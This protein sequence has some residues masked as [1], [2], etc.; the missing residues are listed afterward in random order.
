MEKWAIKRIG[1]KSLLVVTVI[2]LLAVPFHYWTVDK[3]GVLRNLYPATALLSSWTTSCSNAAPD[4]QFEMMNFG[5]WNLRAAASQ[6]AFIDRSGNL[7]HCESG[8]EGEITSSP[9]VTETSLFQYGS[10]TKPIT[11]ALIINLN[12]QDRLRFEQSVLEIFSGGI[13]NN[14]SNRFEVVTVGNLMRFTAGVSGEAFVDK[15]D[16]WCPYRMNEI[17]KQKPWVAKDKGHRYSNLSYCILGG[18]ASELTG[19]AYRPLVSET[20]DLESYGIKFVD[21]PSQKGWVSPDYRYHD[22]YRDDL[23]PS[24]DYTSISSTGGLGGSAEGYARLIRRLLDLSFSDHLTDKTEICDA[25]KIKNCYGYMFYAYEPNATQI[26]NVKE[27]HMPGF[28]SIV[29]INEKEEVFVW[30]GNSDTPNASSGVM[31]KKFLDLLAER[32]L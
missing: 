22:F 30:L 11:S 14:V 8:W 23:E 27:G 17:F 18:I 19:R 1:L 9:L 2:I 6:S 31:M 15:P 7:H 3:K 13:E 5:L 28:S 12:N 32:W 29:A 4:W 26:I 10:L 25:R 21:A 24:F 20:F 16:S